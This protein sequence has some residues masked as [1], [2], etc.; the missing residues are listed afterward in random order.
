MSTT[1]NKA[2][3][4]IAHQHDVD[5]N[6]KQPVSSSSSSYMPPK[7]ERGHS[8][9]DGG[10]QYHHFRHGGSF[11]YHHH[12]HMPLG[13]QENRYL[14]MIVDKLVSRGPPS[15]SLGN[16]GPL[17]LAGFAATTFMLSAWNTGLLPSTTAAIVLP[18]ALWYGGIAQLLAGMWEFA[19]NNT[20]GAVAFTS[21][22]AFWLSFATV[23][24][25]WKPTG[26]SPHDMNVALG[27]YLLV[28]T[29]FTLYMMIASFRMSVSLAVVFVLLEIAF[30][31]LTAGAYSGNTRV[32]AAGGWFGLFCAGAAWYASS[33]IVINSTYGFQLLPVGV[34]GPFKAK[35]ELK[36]K[37]KA[38]AKRGS[39]A[40]SSASS[41]V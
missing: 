18:V 27:M 12:H 34:I 17:G 4:M 3:E 25:F 33:A 6:D 30:I 37:V 21:Y 31:L 22:G 7:Y 16:P 23:E 2:Q 40:Q 19:A 11:P 13:N 28:W 20:F 38:W 26:A 36:E 10:D 5:D 39:N 8:S 9:L 29:I 15:S 32:K 35:P 24:Q 14:E 41:A 1:T